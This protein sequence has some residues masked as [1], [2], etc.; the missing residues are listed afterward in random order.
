MC[1]SKILDVLRFFRVFS[2]GI[3]CS[4]LL[5]AETNPTSNKIF[6]QTRNFVARFYYRWFPL[7]DCTPP[8]PFA[9]PSPGLY[10]THVPGKSKDDVN[11]SQT[12]RHVD[13]GD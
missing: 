11:C 2:F 3:L 10:A 13:H 9:T 7:D 4:R 5:A 12:L 8:L 1:A 6:L